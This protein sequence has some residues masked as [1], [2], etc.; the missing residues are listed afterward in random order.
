VEIVIFEFPNFVLF[1]TF[2]V[3]CLFRFGCGFAVLRQLHC[4]IE[5]SDNHSLALLG[6]IVC[7]HP[8]LH[9]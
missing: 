3:T 8:K 6:N 5:P 2:V 9:P 4:G 1:V 7:A